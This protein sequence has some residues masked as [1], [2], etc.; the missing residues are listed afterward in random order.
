MNRAKV[1]P[2]ALILLLTAC[3]SPAVREQRQAEQ[4]KAPYIL[5]KKDI[6]ACAADYKTKMNDPSSFS[7]AGEA[8][9][10]SD[11]NKLT[12]NQYNKRVGYAVPIR[13]KNGFGGL[14]KKTMFC[15]YSYDEKTKKLD[16]S[17]SL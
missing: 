13:G 14:V 4:S 5:P 3:E 8:Y 6:E 15:F 11:A 10:D 7:V 12:W 2:I 16:F 17:N 1:V 9:Q